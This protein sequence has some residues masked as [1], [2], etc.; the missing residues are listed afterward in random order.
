MTTG[1]DEQLAICTSIE[2]RGIDRELTSISCDSSVSFR[3]ISRCDL[4]LM[5]LAKMLGRRSSVSL[6]S[7]NGRNRGAVDLNASMWADEGAGERVNISGSISLSL[8]K[9]MAIASESGSR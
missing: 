8:G 4:I 2:P 9:L 1:E 5:G 3:L 6:S 7:V